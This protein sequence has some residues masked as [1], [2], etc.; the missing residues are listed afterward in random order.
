MKTQELGK[1]PTQEASEQPAEDFTKSWRYRF[2]LGL[3]I[4]GQVVGSA[5]EVRLL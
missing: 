5:T 3:F 4:A 2:G 1:T